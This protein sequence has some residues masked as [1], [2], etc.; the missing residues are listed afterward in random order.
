MTLLYAK[1][2]ELFDQDFKKS[3]EAQIQTKAKGVKRTRSGKVLFTF[4]KQNNK[5]K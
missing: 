5:R 1:A 2:R 4:R 3:P